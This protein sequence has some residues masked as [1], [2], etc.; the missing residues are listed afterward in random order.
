MKSWVITIPKTVSWEDYQKELA[1]VADQSQV[2]N[3]RVRFA[4]KLMQKGD[5]MFVVHDGVVR[6]YQLVHDIKHWP[7]GFVCQTTQARWEP[8]V[9]IQRT[10]IFH[11][12]APIQMLGFRG[13]RQFDEKDIRVLCDE[14]DQPHVSAMMGGGQARFACRE[15]KNA[16]L[17]GSTMEFQV[18]RGEQIAREK[19][20]KGEL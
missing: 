9:Y 4:P 7:S 1:A 2:L 3:Y 11:R 20:E 5:K 19:M 15:H 16:M 10:G 17:K 12:I 6:G 13:V 14:C 18:R 8:G